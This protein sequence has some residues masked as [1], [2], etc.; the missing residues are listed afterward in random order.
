M[1]VKLKFNADGKVVF[2]QK[3]DKSEI[4]NSNRFIPG[5]EDDCDLDLLK[6]SRP[7]K[8]EVE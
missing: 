7:V 3:D 4:T 2:V 5:K 1:E 8:E 6:Y